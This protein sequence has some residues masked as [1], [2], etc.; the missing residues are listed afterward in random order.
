MKKGVLTILSGFAGSGK[1]TITKELIKRYPD[2]YR[3]SVSATTRNPRVGE[4]DGREYFFKTVEEFEEMIR[5]D[6]LIEYARYVENYYGTPKSYVNEQLR[7]GKDVI[8]EIEIQ[9][10]F[11]VRRLYPDALLLFVSPP[12]IPTVEERLRKRG[13]ETDEVIAKRMRRAAEE[14]ADMDAY[15]YLIINDDL[16][17]CINQVHHVIQ[18]SH[19]LMQN[20]K[21]TTDR[22]KQELTRYMKGE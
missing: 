19:L 21:E 11:A 16:E 22:F 18:S 1:G 12:D 5:Q 17:T 3:L 7:D 14:A 8:L 2:I 9:G 10:A 15:D 13:T 20:N 4:A 6:E